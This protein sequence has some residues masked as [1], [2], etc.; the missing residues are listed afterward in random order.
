MEQTQLM[1]YNRFSLY[2]KCV[3]SLWPNLP[4]TV[5]VDYQREGSLMRVQYP[6]CAYREK[7]GDLTHYYD[8]YFMPTV[9]TH[10]QKSDIKRMMHSLKF[11]LRQ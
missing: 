6:K 3:L 2:V 9:L 11:S 7:E 1:Q 8:K 10:S 4:V 5:G